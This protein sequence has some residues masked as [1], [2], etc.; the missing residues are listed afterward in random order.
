[1]WVGCKCLKI[2]YKAGLVVKNDR[3]FNKMYFLLSL[4]WKI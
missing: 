2:C 3:F 4:L 1:M